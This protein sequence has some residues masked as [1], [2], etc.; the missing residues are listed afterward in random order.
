MLS[1]QDALTIICVT[2]AYTLLLC[3]LFVTVTDGDARTGGGRTVICIVV[4]INV[5]V[6]TG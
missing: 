2:T 1:L 3:E 5:N 4:K 6:Q